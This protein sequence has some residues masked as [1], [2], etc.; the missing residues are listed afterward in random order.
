MHICMPI[1]TRVA[2]KWYGEI[3]GD[4]NDEGHSKLF[5]WIGEHD[6]QP[7]KCLGTL[8]NKP[9]PPY[10]LNRILITWNFEIFDASPD[11]QAMPTKQQSANIG[12]I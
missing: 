4:I 7:A 6:D 12:M 9:N 8:K 11:T 10:V 3:Y 1:S 2:I 5:F